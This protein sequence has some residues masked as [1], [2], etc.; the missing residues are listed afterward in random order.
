MQLRI[1]KHKTSYVMNES[2]M[3]ETITALFHL[4]YNETLNEQDVTSF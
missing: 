2:T 1:L 4:H 3:Q